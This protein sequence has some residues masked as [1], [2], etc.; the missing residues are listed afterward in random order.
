MSHEWMDTSGHIWVNTSGHKWK[1]I[2]AASASGG[3]E[4]TASASAH[5]YCLAS[6]SGD[7]EYTATATGRLVVFASASGSYGLAATAAGRIFC[8][9]SASGTVEFIAVA[10][11]HNYCL[12]SA[13]GDCEFIATASAHNY[14]LASAVGDYECIATANAGVGIQLMPPAMHAALIDPYSGGAWLYLIRVS[15]PDYGLFWYAR[16]TEDVAYGGKT[17]VARNFDVG[18]SP[19]SAD[20]SVPRYG[21]SIAHG[22]DYTLEDMINETQGMAGGVIKVI[23]A[24]E[25]FLDKFILELEQPTNI[26]TASSN[27]EQVIFQMGI[28]SPLLRK[29]LIRRYSSK[30]CPWAKPATF[31]GPECQYAGPD[32]TCTGKYEDCHAKG[33]KVH[34]GADLGLDPNGMKS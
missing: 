16:N 29:T 22:G 6:A 13:V 7:I 3:Y 33:N 25:D 32:P 19:L 15:H 17:Y 21:L 23:R 34:Y 14:C 18:L 9:A 5:N 20:G 26:L 8:L 31:K 10:S 27:A 1:G 24:H 4:F 2:L 12:A 28:P 30:T 11:A